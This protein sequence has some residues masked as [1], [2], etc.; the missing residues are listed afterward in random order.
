MTDKQRGWFLKLSTAQR[1]PSSDLPSHQ[2]FPWRGSL[3]PRKPCRV[4]FVDMLCFPPGFPFFNSVCCLTEQKSH[5]NQAVILFYRIKLIW[6]EQQTIRSSLCCL[7]SFIACSACFHRCGSF[8]LFI[9]GHRVF[10]QCLHM[11]NPFI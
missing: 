6:L 4:V 9:F 5:R 8:R 1:L 10:Q 3:A 11:F 7:C 2:A